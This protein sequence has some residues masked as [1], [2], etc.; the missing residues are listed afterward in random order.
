MLS[1]DITGSLLVLQRNTQITQSTIILM[2]PCVTWHFTI[3]DGLKRSDDPIMKQLTD[4]L[5]N[6]WVSLQFNRLQLLT[7]LA[8]L[9]MLSSRAAS[10]MTANCSEHRTFTSPSVDLATS[11]TVHCCLWSQLDAPQS[12]SVKASRL[13][14]YTMWPDDTDDV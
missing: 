5:C 6:Y 4:L 14:Q 7:T 1:Q 10:S 9:M 2:I 3:Q 11:Q 12:T 13:R 8:A